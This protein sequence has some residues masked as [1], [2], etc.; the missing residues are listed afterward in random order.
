MRAILYVVP[1]AVALVTGVLCAQQDTPSVAAKKDA[2]ARRLIEVSGGAS[3]G[4]EAMAAIDASF[5]RAMSPDFNAFWKDHRETVDPTEVVELIV[6]IYSRRFSLDELEAMVAFHTS[7]VGVH[8]N[9]EYSAIQQ[10]IGAVAYA[11]G[12]EL[13]RRVAKNFFERANR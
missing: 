7:P 9:S 11:W 13:G 2:A 1:V 6:P 8:F 5:A 4:A 3:L 10:E 12:E